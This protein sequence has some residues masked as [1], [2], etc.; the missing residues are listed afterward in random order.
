MRA[1]MPNTPALGAGLTDLPSVDATTLAT[2]DRWL[3]DHRL[4]GQLPEAAIQALAQALHPLT[5][6][7]G[8][9]LFQP[10]SPSLGLYLLKRG[11]V[12]I[13]RPSALGLLLVRQR[14]DGDLFGHVSLMGGRH[15]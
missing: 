2:Q 3:R 15:F 4:W 12:A 1:E 7:A 5:A 9:V 8:A 14:S 10:Q 13:Y 6:G 11:S